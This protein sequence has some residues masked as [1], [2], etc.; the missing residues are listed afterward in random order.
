MVFSTLFIDLDETLYP[1]QS[2]VWDAIADRI[3]SYMLEILNFQPEE[4]HPVRNRL[5]KQYGTTLKGLQTVCSVDK[6]DFLQYV[7]DV[8]VFD[9]L[10]PNPHL[11]TVLQRYPQRKVIF[12]NA[13]HPHAERVVKALGL[14][15]CF[16]QI[17][18]IHDI[19]PYCK[20]D[21]EAYQIALQR[22]GNPPPGECILIDD[23]LSNLTIARQLGFYTILVGGN[24]ARPDCDATISRLEDLPLVLDPA[25]ARSTGA[26]D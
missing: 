16:D 6:N 4:I 20:P 21:P 14:E 3:D 7:H 10:T 26:R 2:G 25:L 11:R 12:T 23:K 22:A 8:P 19:T 1:R 13:D 24:G 17:T 9:L 15:G 5:F 18:D